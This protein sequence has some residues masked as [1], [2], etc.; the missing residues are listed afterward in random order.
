MAEDAG[1]GIGL[2]YFGSYIMDEGE[3]KTPLEMVEQTL[4]ESAGE[5]GFTPLKN[6]LALSARVVP[7]EVAALE[8]QE[9]FMRDM[10]DPYYQGAV[11]EDGA[12]SNLQTMAMGGEMDYTP[13]R[14]FEYQKRK[15]LENIK[16]GQAKAG[17]LHSSATESRKAGFMGDLAAEESERAYGGQLSR[18]QM[19]AGAAGAV[20]AAGSSVS[21]NIGAL[22]SN[23]GSR[24]NLTQQ[25]YGQAK[26]AI[27][28]T[29][30]NT[31][32]NLAAY[33]AQQG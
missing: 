16:T 24:L 21:G 2:Q 13:S 23:I 30:G 26:Q 12:L 10:Y 31:L 7:E 5:G 4:A 22:Y 14:L 9:S 18:V 1:T 11:G 25:A 32:S 15:G 28:Q 3:K 29:A 6:L 17:L 27:F 19:G 20:S 33:Q 8:E